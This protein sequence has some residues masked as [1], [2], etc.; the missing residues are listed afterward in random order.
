M[1]FEETLSSWGELADW[2]PGAKFVFYQVGASP[3]V[4]MLC[5]QFALEPVLKSHLDTCSN[6]KMFWGWVASSMTQDEDGVTI[7]AVHT[8][9]SGEPQEKVFRGKYLVGCDGGSSWVCKQLGIHTF[10]KFVITRAVTI[11]F[12]SPELYARMKQ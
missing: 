7:K 8:P 9:T 2:V 6:T 10:G 11:T 4:P 5:P 12:R 3:S 1:I